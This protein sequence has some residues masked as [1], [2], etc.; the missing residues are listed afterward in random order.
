MS[1]NRRVTTVV[2]ARLKPLLAA[3]MVLGSVGNPLFVIA[4][5]MRAHF[6]DVGQGSA[7]I[8][9]FPC[10]AALVDTGGETN[11]EFD[12]SDQLMD[13]LEDFFA[14]RQDLKETFHLMVL[15]HPHIDHTRGV[16]AVLQKYRILNALTN[17]QEVSSG[18]AGQKALHK[19]IAD[20]EQN[21][22][23]ADNIGYEPIRVRDI[24]LGQGLTNNIIDPVNC[25]NVDPKITA[26]WGTA[27]KTAGWTK[28]AFNNQNN[29]SVVLRVDFGRGSLLLT[30]D[31]EENGIAGLL[32]RYKNT[33]LLDA[34]IYLVGHH[35][36]ANATTDALLRAVTPEIAVVSMGARERQTNWTAWQY[37]HP[38]KVIVD[39]L[40]KHVSR[41]RPA[42]KVYVATGQRAF[43]QV[44][45]NRAIYA[46]GWDGAI[47]IEG[48]VNGSWRLVDQKAALATAAADSPPLDINTATADQ[49]NALPMIGPKRAKD[50]VLYRDRHGRFNS[51]DD[52]GN[53]AGIGPGTLKAIRPFIQVNP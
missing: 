14:S 44:S 4:Q 31:L 33:K 6:L 53:V 29:H 10:A 25:G 40:T 17:G 36:A 1:E 19:K 22:N 32:A 50:I 48:D 47:V 13:Q 52:L 45:I 21:N 41:T 51:I 20:S 37:G 46:T 15:T 49:F 16:K 5:T 23:P 12:S 26:L 11:S 24:P 27:T 35:G 9:E 43:T 18:K 34:D 42:T 39:L 7:T 3:A 28:E 2:L 30:G 8:L 38:R